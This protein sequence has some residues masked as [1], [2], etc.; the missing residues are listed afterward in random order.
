M[1][2]VDVIPHITLRW[3]ACWGVY[4]QIEERRNRPS[5]AAGTT[6]AIRKT[7]A[8]RTGKLHSIS[9]PRYLRWLNLAGWD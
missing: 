1:Y 3:D 4:H 7:N 5:H 9:R 2:P 8:K 6:G